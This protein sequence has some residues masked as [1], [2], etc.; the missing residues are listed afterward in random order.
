MSSKQTVEVLRIESE[1][2]WRIAIEARRA[3]ALKEREYRTALG[4]A[5]GEL[6]T[7]YNESVEQ[8]KA[9]EGNESR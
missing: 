6:I 5:L 8:E 7:E 3:A 2:L 4:E 1:R 9:K